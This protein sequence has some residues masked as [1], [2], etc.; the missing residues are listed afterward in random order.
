MLPL[1]LVGWQC[2]ALQLLQSQAVCGCFDLKFVAWATY[3]V[4]LWVNMNIVA[5]SSV[6]PDWAVCGGFDF[7]LLCEPASA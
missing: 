5:W 3:R 4:G 1:P 2:W 7:N 6:H